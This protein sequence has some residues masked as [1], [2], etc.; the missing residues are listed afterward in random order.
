MTVNLQ[1]ILKIFEHPH[2]YS[3][4]VKTP[5]EAE[6]SEGPGHTVVKQIERLSLPFGLT[7][8]KSQGDERVL[9]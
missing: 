9:R 7:S 5:F 3:T 1:N 8:A 6:N 2:C 4:K